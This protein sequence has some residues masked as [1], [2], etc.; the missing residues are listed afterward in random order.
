MDRRFLCS[1]DQNGGTFRGDNHDPTP[2]Q[3]RPATTADPL[4]DYSN[5]NWVPKHKSSKKGFG[6]TCSRLRRLQV[7]PSHFGLSTF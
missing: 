3:A 7:S 5:M 6:D 4:T 1:Q 2:P